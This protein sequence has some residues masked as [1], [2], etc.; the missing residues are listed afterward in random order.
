MECPEPASYYTF[1]DIRP[2]CFTQRSLKDKSPRLYCYP[3][4]LSGICIVHW[5]SVKHLG[6]QVLPIDPI[7]RFHYFPLQFMLPTLHCP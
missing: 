4:T 2:E 6:S 5:T 7:S 1:L 3:A